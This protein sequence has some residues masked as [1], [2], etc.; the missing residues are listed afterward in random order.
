MQIFLGILSVFLQKICLFCKKIP[1]FWSYYYFLNKP[2]FGFYKCIYKKPD[3]CRAFC[4]E[5][6]LFFIRDKAVFLLYVFLPC[7]FSAPH[8]PFLF[9]LF[10][11]KGDF[12]V[13][14]R[15]DVFEP[16]AYVFMYCRF[17]DSEYNGG[18]ADCIFRFYDIFS[19]ADRPVPCV[20]FQ[21]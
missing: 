4:L 17:T 12:S 21:K 11:N 16:L 1:R 13:K 5:K 7:R 6:F 19:E 10:Q 9:V 8:V 20:S 15:I 3:L 14:R 18:F 2:Y